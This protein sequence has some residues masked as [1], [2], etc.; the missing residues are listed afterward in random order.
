MDPE[1]RLLLAIYGGKMRNPLRSDYPDGDSLCEVLYAAFIRIF[2][3]ALG[4]D[5]SRYEFASL[6]YDSMIVE[7]IG[8]YLEE[9][10]IPHIVLAFDK[11]NLVPMPHRVSLILEGSG[12]RRIGTYGIFH[13]RPGTEEEILYFNYGPFERHNRRVALAAYKRQAHLDAFVADLRQYAIE[14]RKSCRTILDYAGEAAPMEATRWDDVILPPDLYR[15]IRTSIESFLNGRAIYERAGLP[16][17]RGILLA[18]NPGNGKTILSKA[19]AWESGLPFI[20]F[21]LTTAMTEDELDDA[22]DLARDLAP[23]IICFEDLDS[24]KKTHITL[25][26]FLNKLDGFGT[27]D[28]ILILA[29]TN[30]PEEIDAALSNRPSRFDSV[31][32]IPNPDADCRRRAIH[33]HFGESLGEEVVEKA[34]QRTRDFTMAY[35]KEVYLLSVMNAITHAREVPTE[36]DVDT[37]LETL[38]KQILSANKPIEEREYEKM[39]FSLD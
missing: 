28:G 4:R 16:Y 18:G 27:L 3:E 14:R 9:R 1:T 5:P 19:I 29:T 34:V 22:F 15:S 23:A 36:E 38:T 20:L 32:R 2:R 24:I 17:K 11:D 6:H 25:S 31:F 21:P 30:K 26:Y 37:A 33:H 10:G 8:P 12:L 39:G 13:I 35:M 7:H